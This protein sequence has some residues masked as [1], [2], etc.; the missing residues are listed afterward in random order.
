MC[1]LQKKVIA[2]QI[3]YF[4]CDVQGDL[5]KKV[6]IPQTRCFLCFA[7][8]Q[9]KKDLNAQCQTSCL[10]TKTNIILRFSKWKSQELNNGLHLWKI[11]AKM[12]KNI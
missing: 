10:H 3:R 12:P 7:G 8:H 6:I 4:L 11:R 1:D 2:L 9:Q 5:K